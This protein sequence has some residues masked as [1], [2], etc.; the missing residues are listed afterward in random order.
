MSFSPSKK[1]PCSP[2]KY[3]AVTV[4]SEESI[5]T[6]FHSL[7]SL[8]MSIACPSQELLATNEVKSQEGGPSKC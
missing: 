5:C 7:S 3:S 2:L 1:V 4:S 8:V 6:T